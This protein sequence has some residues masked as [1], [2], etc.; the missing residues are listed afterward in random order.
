MVENDYLFQTFLPGTDYHVHYK[1]YSGMENHPELG[2]P[3]LL[4]EHLG[5]Q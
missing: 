1:E 5:I 3:I 4:I 2:C